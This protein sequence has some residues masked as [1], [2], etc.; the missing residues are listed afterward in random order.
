[1]SN[2]N[3]ADKIPAFYINL[4]TVTSEQMNEVLSL[5]VELGALPTEAVWDDERQ[6][7]YLRSKFSNLS[8]VEFY[9]KNNF[10]FAGIN[11]NEVTFVSDN[12]YNYNEN[13]MTYPD[14]MQM[15]KELK[16]GEAVKEVNKVSKTESLKSFY[17][18]MSEANSDPSRVQKLFEGFIELGAVANELVSNGENIDS[19]R[20]LH[21]EKFGSNVYTYNMDGFEFFGLTKSED[22]KS[23]FTYL[24]DDSDQW[25]EDAVAMTIEEAEDY[26]KSLQ[27]SQKKSKVP[28]LRQRKVFLTYTNDKQYLLKNVVGLDIKQK[29]GYVAVTY[30]H[31][32]GKVSLNTNVVIPFSELKS[33]KF[34]APGTIGAEYIFKGGKVVQVIQ[35]FSHEDFTHKSH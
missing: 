7:D 17:V 14:A 15:L 29:E 5:A 3:I 20:R 27:K 8:H 4:E 9:I 21:R 12:I 1:M 22:K 6:E 33:V 11:T 31:K 25:D 10:R 34:V 28:A 23:V 2:Q 13:K 24:E 32:K 18:N 19:D 35:D 30:S 26:L 16:G